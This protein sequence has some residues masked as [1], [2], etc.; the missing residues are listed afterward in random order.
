VACDIYFVAFFSFKVQKE[1]HHCEG[2]GMLL[3]TTIACL[4]LTLCNIG[5][6]GSRRLVAVGDLHG[7]LNQTLSVLRL[8]G[9]I[10]VHTHWIGGNTILVQVGDVLDVG[11]Q[12]IDIVRL[13][14]KLSK[15][16]A[17]AGGQVEQLLGNHEIRNFDGDYSAVNEQTLASQG[18]AE[19]RRELLSMENPV[20]QYL[21]TRNAIFH[22][23]HFLFM[24]G[25][26]STNTV[27]LITSLDKVPVF[28]NALRAALTSGNAS[29]EMA[30]E[31]L[32]LDEGEDVRV[33]NPILVRSI[34]N[35]KCGELHRVLEKHFP[36]INTVVVGH[37]PHDADDFDNWSLC[38]GALVDIDFGM[39]T[40]KK[41]FNGA[42]AALEIFEENNTMILLRDDVM[43]PRWLPDLA[44]VEYRITHAPFVV[45]FSIV[46]AVF[47]FTLTLVMMLFRRFV[48]PASG[49]LSATAA[50][51]YGTF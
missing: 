2:A 47:L 15:Q 1:K 28:N 18:G 7:D 27:S 16:A 17:E 20:G 26:F 9:L 51:Q 35:V 23:N 13:F 21:R 31:G 12:D 5:C 10:D 40:W 11:P 33:K 19:G 14:M 8:T 45:R 30:R 37:V 50:Q 32:N 41:G 6:E 42:V 43:L 39:S 24:H 22:H 36:S 25:G 38:G 29:T 4:L 34:L 48:R 46:A 49:E 3:S 44:E